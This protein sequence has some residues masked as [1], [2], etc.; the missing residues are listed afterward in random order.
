MRNLLLA[1]IGSACAADFTPDRSD[2]SCRGYLRC[3]NGVVI[4]HGQCQ[5]G[6]VWDP[7]I[8]NC[9]WPSAV[10]SCTAS[11]T[12]AATTEKLT[13]AAVDGTTVASGGR[14]LI[15]MSQFTNAGIC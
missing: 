15:T 5:E 14:G 3:A 1:A 6:L 8:K 12:T 7:S 10:T 11:A 9:N 13:T 2:P 4:G